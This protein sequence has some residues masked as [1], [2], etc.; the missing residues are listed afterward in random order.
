[1]YALRYIYSKVSDIFLNRRKFTKNFFESSYHQGGVDVFT[2]YRENM[3][4]SKMTD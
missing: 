2:N 1:M 3:F 4:F